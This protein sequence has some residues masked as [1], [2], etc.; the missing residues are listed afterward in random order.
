MADLPSSLD[1]AP[2]HAAEASHGTPSGPV[3]A[4]ASLWTTDA[5][6]TL[7]ILAFLAILATRLPASYTKL[8][9]FDSINLAYAL[10]EF[11]PTLNQPQPPGY[12]LFVLIAR[13]LQPL[14]GEPDI[15]FLAMQLLVSGLAVGYLYKLTTLL[16]SARIALFSAALLLFNP[17]FWYS[18]LT[19]AL[20][21]HLALMPI[22]FAYYCVQAID[23]RRSNFLIASFIL[24]IAGGIRPEL[25]VVLFPLWVWTGWK[26]G[27]ARVLLRGFGIVCLISWLWLANLAAASGGFAHMMEYFQQYLGAQTFQSSVLQASAPPGWRRMFGRVTVWLSL[28]ALPWLWTI[29]IGW[30]QEVKG[31][32]NIRHFV[33]LGLWLIPSALLS[34]VLHSADPDHLLSTIP[35]ICIVGGLCLEAAETRLGFQWWNFAVQ[36]RVAVGAGFVLL[37]IALYLVMPN[38]PLR[39]EPLTMVRLAICA[40]IGLAVIAV[41][42]LRPWGGTWPLVTLALLGNMLLFFG[43]FPFP[44]GPGSGPFRGL[45]SVRDAF[46][47]GR[48]ESSFARVNFANDR[49][50]RALNDVPPLQMDPRRPVIFIWSRD[51]EPAWRKLT[52]YFPKQKIYVLEEAGDPGVPLTSATLWMANK[53]SARFSGENPVM[54]PIPRNARLIWFTGG[55]Q[56]AELAKMLLVRGTQSFLYTDV[57]GDAAPI[58]WGSF[59]FDPQ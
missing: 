31:T 57:A 15:T 20:R 35:V 39:P 36:R 25:S 49:L 43:E 42:P 44:Q 21:L 27:D 23:N 45:A 7:W 29:F 26:C 58:H 2:A 12:P 30:K 46:L 52:Y 54:L 10:T 5:S 9:S 8:Y 47:G 56:R 40:G 50:D 14:F 33:L 22:L 55:A 24:G 32:E 16:F 4:P 51:G 28:G 59:V 13:S 19:S 18:G 37:L 3:P 34:M 38:D 48:Y 41:S 6:W 1:T 53:V 17:V 11:N